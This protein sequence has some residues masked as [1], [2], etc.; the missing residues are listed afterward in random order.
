MVLKVKHSKNQIDLENHF[1]AA[2]YLDLA[3]A[4]GALIVFSPT[5]QPNF[6]V[7][8]AQDGKLLKVIDIQI[9]V[10]HTLDL[11]MESKT[12]LLKDENE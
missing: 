11:T 2:D 4:R 8:V 6:D 9:K 7:H 1:Y 10:L 12:N 3:K 5:A